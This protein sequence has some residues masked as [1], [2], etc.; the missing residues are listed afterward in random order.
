MFDKIIDIIFNIIYYCMC[1]LLAL[2]LF[3]LSFLLFY[4][5]DSTVVFVNV[6]FRILSAFWLLFGV[7]YVVFCIRNI[8]RNITD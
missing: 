6:S 8:M 3:G 2:L 7:M 5:S 4:F 1:L